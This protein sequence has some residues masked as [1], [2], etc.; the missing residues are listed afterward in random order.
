MLISA[1]EYQFR[2]QSASLLLA[3]TIYGCDRMSSMDKETAHGR[4][5]G[6]PDWS[7]LH[8]RNHAQKLHDVEAETWHA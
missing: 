8:R 6:L 1:S 5:V 7:H 4:E 2:L 3:M